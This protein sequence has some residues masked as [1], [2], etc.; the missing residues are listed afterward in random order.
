[1][2][3]RLAPLLLV[4]LPG[5]AALGIG[6]G[7]DGAAPAAPAGP[8]VIPETQAEVEAVVATAGRAEAVPS[9]ARTAEAFDTTTEAERVIAKAAAEE[10]PEEA[11]EA[12]G[13]TIASLGDP[14][15]PGLWLATPLVAEARPGRLLYPETGESVLVELRSVGGPAT[16]GSRISLPAIRLLGAP[17]AG[18]PEI[19]VFGR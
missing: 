3:P 12:L 7:P 13:T 5:C 1:M 9:G 19:E 11:E 2:T 18:L 15:D 14:A 17:L 6:A 10:P 16:G 4:A 8:V